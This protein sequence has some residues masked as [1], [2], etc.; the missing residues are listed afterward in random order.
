MQSLLS[1]IT[2][3]EAQQLQRDCHWIFC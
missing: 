1:V 3:Q 2:K